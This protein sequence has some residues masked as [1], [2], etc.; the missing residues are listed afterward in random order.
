[1][2]ELLYDAE[3]RAVAV[4][5]LTDERPDLGIEAAYAIQTEGRRLREAGGAVVVGRKIGLTSDAMQSQLGVDQPDFGYLTDRMIFADGAV[6]STTAL[7][8][9]RVEAEIAFRLDSPLEGPDVNVDDVL[10]ATGAVAAAFEVIDSRI[11][12][13]RI[14][15]ADT[16]ADN[17]SSSGVVLGEFRPVEQLDLASV[18]LEM[19]VTGADGADETVQGLGS[20]VMGHP[21]A[22]IA[23]LVRTL[24]AFGAGGIGAGEI[25]IP[26][27]MARSLP[28]AAGSRVRATF[29]DLGALAASFGT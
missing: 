23:W 1:M 24:H 17:A 25:V 20:A 16:I 6:L 12:D 19:V 5:P 29:S 26:G 28:V 15:I 3:R 14:K 13:W 4:S 2:A 11:A 9:P 7:I 8:A 22:A 10:G 21:A 27:A 18:E